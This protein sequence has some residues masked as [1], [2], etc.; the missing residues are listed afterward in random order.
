MWAY[1]RRLVAGIDRRRFL[2]NYLWLG[3][4]ALFWI[5][6]NPFRLIGFDQPPSI[7]LLSILGAQLDYP[8]DGQSAIT[9]LTVSEK[10][11]N[12]R[13][14]SWPLPVG[15]WQLLLERIAC[16]APR[17]LFVDA[18]L[19]RTEAEDPGWPGLAGMIAAAEDGTLTCGGKAQPR[20]PVLLARGGAADEIGSSRVGGDNLAVTSWLAESGYPLSASSA[21]EARPTAAYALLRRLCAEPDRRGLCPPAIPAIGGESVDVVWGADPPPRTAALVKAAGADCLTPAALRDTAAGDIALSLLERRNPRYQPC[22]YHHHLS[23]EQFTENTKAC[24]LRNEEAC[25]LMTE[26][27]KDRVIM[28]GVIRPG[29]A[30][31]VYSPI[32]GSLPGV[33]YHAMALDN[34]FV[35]GRDYFK[36]STV[37]RLKIW[38]VT[39]VFLL[40]PALVG[41][42]A[43]QSRQKWWMVSAI[44][45]VSFTSMGLVFY[46][47]VE[48]HWLSP[49]NASMLLGLFMMFVEAAR[50][51]LKLR[52]YILGDR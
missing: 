8:R 2:V 33:F 11:L 44:L 28:I 39:M 52:D 14:D 4:L 22:S 42:S 38:L 49:V 32:H 6:L 29:L 17:A 12:R 23:L 50:V 21:E 25:A 35:M 18:I 10:E 7:R 3:A 51:E 19:Y 26:L 13:G 37:D 46:L 16:Y 15:Q 43:K 5:V 30:D 36:T 48:A 34:L 45:L 24:A 41:I 27:F 1:C 47:S 20:F 40:I 31:T 9:V